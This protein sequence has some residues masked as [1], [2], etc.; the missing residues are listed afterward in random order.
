MP[1]RDADILLEDITTA[2]GRIERY[3]AGLERAQFL[4]DEKTIERWSATW[5]SAAKQCD[6]C[7]RSSR[8]ETKGFHGCRL[9]GCETGSCDYF[10]LDLEIIWQV[11][12]SSLPEFKQQ[13]SQ[14]KG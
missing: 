1:E 14:L 12:K 9:P 2:L 10:G 3:V 8:S 13:L 6:G 4:Q 11:I 7:R 5:R